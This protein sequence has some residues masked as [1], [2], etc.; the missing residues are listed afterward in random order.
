MDLVFEKSK[1]GR[2]GA[3]EEQRFNNSKNKI[4]T[5]QKARERESGECDMVGVEW[6]L[7]D[8]APPDPLTD[9]VATAMRLRDEYCSLRGKYQHQ[10][11]LDRG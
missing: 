7:P 5:E 1:A 11:L 6:D 4:K 10:Q 9:H 2:G 3:E 8:D